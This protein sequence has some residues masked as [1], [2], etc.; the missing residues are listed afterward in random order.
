MFTFST[1][2][3]YVFGDYQNVDASQTI[4]KV[5][6]SC[7]S[8]TN[9]NIYPL[10]ESNLEL[11]GIQP[12]EY[13]MKDLPKAIIVIPLMMILFAFVST[14]IQSI[15]ENKIIANELEKRLKRAGKKRNY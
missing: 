6:Y 4:V 12:A 8:G 3:V 15:I 13:Q 5:S 10:T 7:P 14:W 1:N 11:L 2:G 9:N